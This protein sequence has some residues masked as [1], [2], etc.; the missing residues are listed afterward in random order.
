MSFI[1]RINAAQQANNSL[2]NDF[3][4]IAKPYKTADLLHKLQSL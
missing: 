1:G 3:H 4:F 2:V